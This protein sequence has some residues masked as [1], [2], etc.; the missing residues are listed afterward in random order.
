[1]GIDHPAHSVAVLLNVT[2]RHRKRPMSRQSLNVAQAAAISRNIAGH[3]GDEGSPC[4]EV[5]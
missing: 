5:G 1:M 3:I 4:R 2:L